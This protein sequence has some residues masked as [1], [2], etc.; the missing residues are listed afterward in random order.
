MKGWEHPTAPSPRKLWGREL[1]CP[2]CGAGVLSQA[3]L[4]VWDAWDPPRRELAGCPQCIKPIIDRFDEE[5]ELRLVIT[6][7]LTRAIRGLRL[8]REQAAQCD[9]VQEI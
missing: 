9:H 5:L 3:A 6:R 7:Q 8:L 1:T 4:W 2:S